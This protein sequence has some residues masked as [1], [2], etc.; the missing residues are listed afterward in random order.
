MQGARTHEVHGEPLSVERLAGA[1]RD[2]I[3]ALTS[4][5]PDAHPSP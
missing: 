1:P 4:A 3:G 5:S 2:A